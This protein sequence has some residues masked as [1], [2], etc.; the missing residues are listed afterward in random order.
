ML[1]RFCI[2]NLLLGCVDHFPLQIN[3]QL[4]DLF[5]YFMLFLVFENHMT[6]GQG[7]TYF[8]AKITMTDQGLL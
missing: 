8:I 5:G 6:N 4:V 3:E 2:E 1:H 7:I